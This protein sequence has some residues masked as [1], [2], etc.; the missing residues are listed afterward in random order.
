MTDAL[1]G[2]PRLKKRLFT[3]MMVI[4]WILC[5]TVIVFLYV[6]LTSALNAK[7]CVQQFAYVA[8][9][10]RAIEDYKTES[11]KYPTSLRS[12]SVGDPGFTYLSDGASFQ[13]A[14]VST[15]EGPT[16]DSAFVFVV[17]NGKLISWPDALSAERV[18]SLAKRRPDV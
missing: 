17:R 10:V 5:I 3:A 6:N 7:S 4:P 18:K 12:L 11:G 2:N 14:Y 9:V 13:L 8:S 16:P 1:K 15:G